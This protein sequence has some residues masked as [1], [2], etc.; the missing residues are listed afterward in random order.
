MSILAIY[1]AA[2]TLLPMPGAKVL[3]T[4]TYNMLF[5]ACQA[6][7]FVVGIIGHLCSLIINFALSRRRE[8]LADAGA[9]E[10]TKNPDAMISALRKIAGRSDVPTTI[11][12]VR[13]MFFDN[14]HLAGIEGLFATHPP[15]EKRIE[16]LIRYAR[17]VASP[18]VQGRSPKL[19]DRVGPPLRRLTADYYP[20]LA[21]VVLALSP[22]TKAAR[23]AAY[24]RVRQV[25]QKQLALLEPPLSRAEIEAEQLIL[26]ETIG[27]LELENSSAIENQNSISRSDVPE[28]ASIKNANRRGRNAAIVATSTIAVLVIA[29]AGYLYLGPLFLSNLLPATADADTYVDWSSDRDGSPKTYSVNGVRIVLRSAGDRNE[30]HP[31]LEVTS[32][33]GVNIAVDGP[34]QLFAKTAA[35][36]V[37]HLDPAHSKLDI[38]FGSYTYGAHC[39]TA[40]KVLSLINGAWRL[41]DLGQWDGDAV[42]EPQ[43]VNGEVALIFGDNTFLYSFAPYAASAMPLKILL[44]ENGDILDA[45][46]DSNFQPLHEKNMRENQQLCARHLNGGCAAYVASAARIGLFDQAWSFMLQNFDPQSNW[47]LNFCN[48]SVA[49]ECVTFASFPQ[50]LDWFLRRQAYR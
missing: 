35:I 45:S 38:I 11:D 46:R 36:R 28:K 3:V 8:F 15:I 42:P 48:P 34:I 4:V 37:T 22:N 2:F 27:R 30:G 19:A 23:E 44:I 29:I 50:A 40:I 14:P 25:L 24:Q 18:D 39:C 33:A 41:V 49:S 20:L 43:H 13:E 21:K 5:W 9:V 12:G 10:L 6:A 7:A 16:A 47:S 31:R 1:R 26:S 32:P 17:D